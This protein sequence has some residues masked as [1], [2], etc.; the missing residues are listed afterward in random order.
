MLWVQKDSP[1]KIKKQIKKFG[2]DKSKRKQIRCTQHFFIKRNIYSIL[3]IYTVDTFPRL[4][5]DAMNTTWTDVLIAEA[6]Y[7]PNIV[8]FTFN[9]CP[10]SFTNLHFVS[11]SLSEASIYNLGDVGICFC[12]DT[13]E[14]GY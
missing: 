11:L 4:I 5:Q 6:A 12:R 1:D 13:D 9:S 3:P 14:Q 8:D 2:E 7:S 10:G